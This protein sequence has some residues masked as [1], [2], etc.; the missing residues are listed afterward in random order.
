MTRSFNLPG[1]VRKD[2]WKTQARFGLPLF[3][4]LA[5]LLALLYDHNYL[6][7]NGLIISSMFGLLLLADTLKRVRNL[8]I[9]AHCFIEEQR[10]ITFLSAL[11]EAFEEFWQK[12]QNGFNDDEMKTIRHEIKRKYGIDIEEVAG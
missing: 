3:G 5:G 10:Q 4:V 11:D 8:V 1:S 7:L 6:G 12:Y 9:V 2:I